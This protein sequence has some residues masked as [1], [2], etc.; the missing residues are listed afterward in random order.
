MYSNSSHH[1]QYVT[2][3]VTTA[4]KGKILV[5]LFEGCLSFLNQAKKGLEENNIVKFAKFNSKAQAIISEL[6]V[7]LDFEKGGQIAKDLDRIYD[8]LLFHL[9]EANLQKDPK[10]IE[11]VISILSKVASAYKEIVNKKPIETQKTINKDG[12]VSI[13]QQNLQTISLSL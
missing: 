11:N 2:N 8:F 7:T 10:K 13:A 5:M 12:E 1:K 9:V 6:M 4:D 3:Q